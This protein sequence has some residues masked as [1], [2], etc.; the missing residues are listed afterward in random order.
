VR[1][2][3]PR[4]AA[5]FPAAASSDVKA[6]RIGR[7]V[8]RGSAVLLALAF[9]GGAALASDARPPADGG[10]LTGQSE[11]Q[12]LTSR[13]VGTTVVS[14]GNETIGDVSDVV[15][16]RDG[17]TVALVIGVGGFLG[18]GEKTVA[19]PLD[20]VEMQPTLTGAATPE[21][22]RRTPDKVVLRATRSDLQAA[23]EFHPTPRPLPSL[24]RLG[25]SHP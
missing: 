13:V 10:F 12:W 1:S 17:R 24:P 23:P 2:S 21:G 4:R 18:I 19:V 7:T 15:I 5:C 16:G 22:G 8:A 6:A 14:A 20:R 3:A 9:A 25:S 11:G